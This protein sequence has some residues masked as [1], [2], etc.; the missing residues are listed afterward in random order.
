M[1]SFDLLG[2]LRAVNKRWSIMVF[3]TTNW[4]ENYAL[5]NFRVRWFGEPV[6]VIQCWLI[7]SAMKVCINLFKSVIDAG[8]LIKLIQNEQLIVLL[9]INRVYFA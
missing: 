5:K 2:Q 9:Y 1:T 8:S 4:G 3:T 7:Y 6:N